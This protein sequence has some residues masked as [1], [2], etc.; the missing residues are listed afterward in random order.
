MP[1]IQFS[2]CPGC[3]WSG[4]LGDQ[5]LHTD[6]GY[7]KENFEC[8]SGYRSY[9]LAVEC[10]WTHRKH[11]DNSYREV[12]TLKMLSVRHSEMQIRHRMIGLLRGEPWESAIRQ[13]TKL[14]ELPDEV[15]GSDKSKWLREC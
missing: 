2:D 8:G 13:L 15:Q 1:L 6:A 5:Q 4:P 7:H 3:R 9:R 11:L 14:R 12:K 10:L